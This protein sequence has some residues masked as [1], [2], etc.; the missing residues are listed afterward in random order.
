MMVPR[1]CWL[2]ATDTGLA[3]F[4]LFSRQ[5]PAISDWRRAKKA[6]GMRED[7]SRPATVK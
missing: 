1:K 7:G 4:H 5:N 3:D 2:L 6:H